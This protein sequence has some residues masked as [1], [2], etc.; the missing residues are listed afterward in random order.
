MLENATQ[1]DSQSSYTPYSHDN[2]LVESYPYRYS[3]DSMYSP[4][5]MES[6]TETEEGS[7]SRSQAS[8]TSYHQRDNSI[9]SHA[10]NF[11]V[12]AL[13]GI[14]RSPTTATSTSSRPAVMRLRS[15]SASS[16]PAP[17]P[18]GPLPPLPSGPSPLSERETFL[19]AQ[20]PDAE[21]T[22]RSR[23]GASFN[24]STLASSTPSPTKRTRLMDLLPIGSPTFPCHLPRP[25]LPVQKRISD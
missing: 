23:D 12:S 8:F 15:N 21:L 22:R 24:G 20:V 5:I 6:F 9:T 3:I 4:S 7:Y 1:R 10:S 18:L 2:R 16:T 25:H 17:P 11:T 13:G 14:P 19:F